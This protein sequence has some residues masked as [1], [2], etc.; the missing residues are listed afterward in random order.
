MHAKND[1]YLLIR[2]RNSKRQP[3]GNSSVEASFLVENAKRTPSR[4]NPKRAA[5]IDS[6]LSRPTPKEAEKR[7]ARRMI[8]ANYERKGGEK[9]GNNIAK[10][11]LK[12]SP[13]L[14]A[15]WKL[16]HMLPFPY[17]SDIHQPRL[18]PLQPKPRIRN[19]DMPFALQAAEQ[20]EVF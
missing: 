6:S 14:G 18:V 1:T 19:G 7:V 9:K 3:K 10:A 2:L 16:F 8:S 20:D 5:T 11:K 15:L 12:Y 4:R 13:H 17:L